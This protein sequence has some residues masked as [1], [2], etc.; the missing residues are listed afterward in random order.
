MEFSTTRLEFDKIKKLIK[1]YTETKQGSALIDTIT[2]SSNPLKIN[3]LLGETAHAKTI[4]NVYQKAPF[5]GIR[6]IRDTLKKAKI[7]SKLLAKDFLDII[8]LIDAVSTNIRFYKQVKE[9]EIQEENLDPYYESLKP[10]KAL[11]DDINRVITVDGEIKSNASKTLENIRNSIQ[12]NRRRVNQKLDSILSKESSKLADQLI[13]MRHDR[14]VVPVKLSEKNNFKGAIIDYSSSGETVYM[15][16]YSVA[17]I[18]NK[19][20]TLE[21]E[22]RQEI[23]RILRELTRKIGKEHDILKHNFDTLSYLD[24]VFAKGQFAFEFECTLPIITKEEVRLNMARHPLIPPK[25]VVPNNIRLNKQERIM[26]ITGPNTGGKTVA[27]KTL[28]LLSI[29]VQSGLLIPVQQDSKTIIFENIYADIG[30]EQSIEQSLST[31]SS[32]MSNI[33]NIIDHISEDSLVL[34]DELGSGT[35]PKEGASLAI[36]ILD[37]LIPK[38]AYIIAT[39]HYP[40]LK[41]Y[42]YDKAEILNASVEFDVDTLSPT[43]KLLLGT[44]GKSNAL[45]ISDR[46]GLNQSI[47]ENA[48]SNVLTSQTEVSDLINKLEKQGNKLEEERRKLEAKER[49]LANKIKDTTDLRKELEAEKRT[50]KEKIKVKE[51]DLLRETKEKAENLIE[52]IEALHKKDQIKEHELAKLKYKI[53]TLHEEEYESSSTTNHTYSPGDTVNILKFNRNGTLLEQLKSGKWLIEMGALKSEFSEEEFEFVGRKKKTPT[54]APK[55]SRKKS[56]YVSSTLDLRGLRY[57]E[58]QAKVDKYIDDC[59][60]ANKPFATIIHGYGT[61][62]LR[63]LVKK[64]LDKHPQVKNHRDGEG[65]EGGKGVTVVY[66]E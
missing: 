7:D 31:F 1:S 42:A 19:I 16:P 45:L 2:P 65:S 18:N 35:D 28:G 30:D 10:T 40:E 54:S 26:I 5:G 4:I 53:K 46:L 8:G 43:Y 63:K 59:L 24:L 50:L 62:T 22:E 29:M 44:P 23:D 27:L 15:E 9:N 38:K 14:A 37:Y 60:L 47:I 33:I 56:K 66:F 12:T 32:H 3:K 25:E 48:K 11:K 17:E 52:E 57:E 39:T 6:D 49:E 20:S 61:L 13:T 34:L 64:Y 58:A 41:A 36:A 21:L 51:S 55:K